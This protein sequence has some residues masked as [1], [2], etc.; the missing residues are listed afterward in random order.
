MYRAASIILIVACLVAAT[1]GGTRLALALVYSDWQLGRVGL[2]VSLSLLLVGILGFVIFIR[3]KGR[4]FIQ[5]HKDKIILLSFSLLFCV[6]CVELLFNLLR[7]VAPNVQLD[8]EVGW[9]G[10]PNASGYIKER[11]GQPG[12]Y[13]WSD[14]FGLPNGIAGEGARTL[15]LIGDSM[16]SPY[17]D[18]EHSAPQVF[19]INPDVSKRFKIANGSIGGYGTDQ[20]LLRLKTLL[21]RIQNVSDVALFFLPLNDFANNVSD[22]VNWKSLGDIPKPFF[23]LKS[24]SLVYHSPISIAHDPFASPFLE[25]FVLYR[26]WNDLRNHLEEKISPQAAP[27]EERNENF[28]RFF[29]PQYTAE[30][31]PEFKQAQQITVRLLQEVKRVCDQHK[32]TLHVFVFD[33]PR[34]LSFMSRGASRE[35]KNRLQENFQRTIEETFR[36]AGLPFTWIVLE[37][38]E[39][40]PKDIHPNREGIARVA[41]IVM[42]EVAGASR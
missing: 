8:P 29:R 7:P 11:L 37:E 13:V 41:Q 25:H 30:Y 33:S 28:E 36:M 21:K 23:E 35:E 26:L 27:I 31:T 40:I 32:A 34:Y 42:T 20:E 10:R 22:H 39:L 9:V 5:R 12:Y 15:L 17:Y 18:P 38:D 4:G 24:D 14:D 2:I 6:V 16:L 19:L 3:E 1:A